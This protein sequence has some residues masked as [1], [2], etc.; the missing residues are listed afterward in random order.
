MRPAALAGLD[1]AP[2]KLVKAA[3]K[4]VLLIKRFDRIKSIDSRTRRAMISALTCSV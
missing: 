1:V 3:G 4:D 2:V